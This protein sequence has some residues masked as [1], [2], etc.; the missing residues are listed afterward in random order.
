MCLSSIERYLDAWQNERLSSKF[1]FTH[2]GDQ[3][4]DDMAELAA[5]LTVCDSAVVSDMTAAHVAGALG[6]PMFLMMD[7]GGSWRWHMAGHE[8][9][10]W[11]PTARTFRQ[12]VYGDWSDVVDRVCNELSRAVAMGQTKAA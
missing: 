1:D 9:S 8:F 3:V 11:Y 7:I 6:R 10:P 4:S 12:T 5:V 2:V